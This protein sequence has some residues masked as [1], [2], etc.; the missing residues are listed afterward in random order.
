MRT[1]A[2]QPQH[3]RT[4]D[5]ARRSGDQCDLPFE[6]AHAPITPAICIG[7]RLPAPPVQHNVSEPRVGRHPRSEPGAKAGDSG[8]TL[9][10]P[11][12]PFTVAQRLTLQHQLDRAE[13]LARI[14][15]R[16]SP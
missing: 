4:A 11:W 3:S 8:P 15:L 9:G 6:L 16:V 5:I 10:G 1:F 13:F 2:G 14:G 7:L 12:Q